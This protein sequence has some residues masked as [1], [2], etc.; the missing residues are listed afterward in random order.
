MSN[1]Y[2]CENGYA[3]GGKDFLQAR[4]CIRGGYRI[5]DGVTY[6]GTMAFC[7]CKGLTSVEI[8]ESV[9]KINIG[10]FRGCDNLRSVKVDASNAVYDS[11]NNCNA[12]IESASNTLV[13]GCQTTEI[14]YGVTKIGDCAFLGC[15]GLT[16]I[17]IPESVT[18]IERF[19]FD[20]CE[21]LESVDVR[22]AVQYVDSSAF[23]GCKSLKSITIPAEAK[24]AFLNAGIDANLLVVE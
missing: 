23:L 24:D 20:S 10:I 1:S 19:A 2:L 4:K 9:T 8:P 11:R 22:S 5:L 13:Q 12:I 3:A 17:E 6:I 14:P 21:N 18:A 7:D 16:S 15:R